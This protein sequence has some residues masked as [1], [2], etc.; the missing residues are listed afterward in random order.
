MD[1]KYASFGGGGNDMKNVNN[2]KRKNHNVNINAKRLKLT[3][4]QHP[5]VIVSAN[6][7]SSQKVETKVEP[8]RENLQEA[9]KLLPVY[10]VKGRFVLHNI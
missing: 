8:L 9:R 5:K 1:S 10:M 4:N 3:S 7:N 6:G 2:F